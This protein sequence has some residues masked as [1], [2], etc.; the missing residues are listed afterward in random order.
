MAGE[1]TGKLDVVL[2]KLADYTE[3]QQQT[4]QKS[5]KHSFILL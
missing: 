1:Q 2:E 4:K 3:R 5:N